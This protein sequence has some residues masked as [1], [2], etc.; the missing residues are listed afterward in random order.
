MHV[1]NYR[2]T[3]TRLVAGLIIRPFAFAGFFTGSTDAVEVRVLTVE[4]RRAGDG[5]AGL[6]GRPEEDRRRRDCSQQQPPHDPPVKRYSLIINITL[7]QQRR[8]LKSPG[9]HCLRRIELYTH[10]EVSL[11]KQVLSWDGVCILI[12]SLS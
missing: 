1:P 11:R 3:L 9:A 5:A 2:H 6:A 7:S 8:K 10:L 4:E 12:N